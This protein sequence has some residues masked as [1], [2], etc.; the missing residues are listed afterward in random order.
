MTRS[1]ARF[2]YFGDES[3]PDFHRQRG[4]LL[5]VSALAYSANKLTDL[6][7]LLRLS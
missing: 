3:L 5:L 6:D 4:I 2:S 7:K 1:I